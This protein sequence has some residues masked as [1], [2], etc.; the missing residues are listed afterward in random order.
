MGLRLRL[1]AAAHL[2]RDIVAELAVAVVHAEERG[3]RRARERVRDGG[4]VLIDLGDR[5]RVGGLGAVARVGAHERAVKGRDGALDELLDLR[6]DRD[7]PARA[8]VLL[9]H[10][11]AALADVELH[12]PLHG[13]ERLAV[14]LL[15][16]ILTIAPRRLALVVHHR[17]LAARR[18]QP[19]RRLRGLL[20]CCHRALRVLLTNLEVGHPEH[21]LQVLGEPSLA[22]ALRLRLLLRG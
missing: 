12:R 10:G 17:V 11:E 6:R 20:R 22:E 7:A 3:A 15:E 8:V 2:L 5:A 16:R 18:R 9:V 13:G 1:A 19:R 4:A 14:H 21:A